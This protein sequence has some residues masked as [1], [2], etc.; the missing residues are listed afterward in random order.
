MRRKKLLIAGVVAVALG[1]GTT[2]GLAA[3]GG[4]GDEPITGAAYERAST[5][6]L[7]AAGGGRVSDTEVG[8]EEGHYEV[9][10]TLEDGSQVDVHLDEDFNVLTTE[11]DRDDLEDEPDGDDD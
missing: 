8:D 11:G 7:E 1:G 4:D 10:V 6:A 2:A 9:E 5:A 3:A